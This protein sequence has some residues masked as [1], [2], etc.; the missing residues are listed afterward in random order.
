MLWKLRAATLKREAN[1]LVFPESMVLMPNQGGMGSVIVMSL[2]LACEG[3]FIPAKRPAILISWVIESPPA[4]PDLAIGLN[5]LPQ[6]NT[7]RCRRPER[8]RH[9]WRTQKPPQ[10]GTP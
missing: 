1:G 8:N 7:W 3:L 5:N 10:H 6:H 9:C 2:N 4:K